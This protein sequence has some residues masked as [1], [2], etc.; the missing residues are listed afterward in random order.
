MATPATIRQHYDDFAPIYR[1]F[2][3]DHIHHGL[4][5]R[6]DE[7][8]QQAQLAMLEH[9]AALAG[10]VP[11]RAL[12]VGCGHGGTAIFLARKFGADVDGLTISP[13]QAR[14]A[15]QNA[16]QAGVAERV[17][18]DVADAD[19]FHFP[20]DTYDLVWTMESS[21]HFRDRAAYF[22]NVARTLR[23]GG[24]LLVAAWTG[25][26]HSHAV[27]EVAR[28]FLCPSLS[29]CEEY[30]AQILAAGLSLVAMEDLTAEVI[31]TWEICRRRAAAG[32][33][34]IRALPAHLRDFAL[35]IDA[36]L[37]AYRSRELT[38]SVIVVEKPCHWA[39]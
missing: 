11:K 7:T 9:C 2:W 10:I 34:A 23:P 37:K 26:M 3:G 35:G 39:R 6:G 4:F 24:R 13:S 5:V 14:L 31:H 19:H 33:M 25:D 22:R 17:H 8:P 28:L 30:A 27:P 36:I 12:D 29:A 18:I 20:A 16:V 1:L 21:E 32:R 15:L 38:Y